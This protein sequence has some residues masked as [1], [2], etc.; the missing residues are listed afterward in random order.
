MFTMEALKRRGWEPVGSCAVVMARRVSLHEPSKGWIEGTRSCMYLVFSTVQWKLKQVRLPLFKF[1]APSV[2][3]RWSS[4]SRSCMD[5]P[6]GTCGIYSDEDE[7]MRSHREQWRQ[8]CW[9]QKAV[10]KERRDTEPCPTGSS[11]TWRR[12]KCVGSNACEALGWA[13]DRH[14]WH[15]WWIWMTPLRTR[16]TC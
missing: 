13:W 14:V 11:G 8:V 6:E 1:Q 5:I 4:Y 12:G 9:Q 7:Y 2:N 10:K 15:L 16:P 3:R